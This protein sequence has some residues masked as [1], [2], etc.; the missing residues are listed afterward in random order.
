M[1]NLINKIRLIIPAVLIKFPQAND[2]KSKD[3]KYSLMTKD[4]LN[5]QNADY[6]CA[7]F[8]PSILRDRC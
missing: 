5:K 8:P 1:S 7:N 3:S 4:I 2:F 6:F